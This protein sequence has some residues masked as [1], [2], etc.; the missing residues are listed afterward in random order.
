[1][2]RQP[3]QIGV[4]IVFVEVIRA[5]GGRRCR[6]RAPQLRQ[7]PN[8]PQAPWTNSNPPWSAAATMRAKSALCLSASR[9]TS[10]C[11]VLQKEASTTYSQPFRYAGRPRISGIPAIKSWSVRRWPKASIP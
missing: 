4:E 3:I 8:H 11:S 5:W 1:M 2:L 9:I 7:E 10:T 6:D